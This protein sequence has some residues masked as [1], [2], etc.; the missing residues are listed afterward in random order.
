MYVFGSLYNIYI[1]GRSFNRNNPQA[2]VVGPRSILFNS[3]DKKVHVMARTLNSSYSY[4]LRS[5]G[6]K[7][8]Q[9]IKFKDIVEFIN[10][11]AKRAQHP[12]FGDL[13]DKTQA[14]RKSL[15]EALS[16]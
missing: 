3:K 13:R 1:A 8:K 10:R 15:H 5:S 6:K 9:R 14:T 11:P 4:S 16:G 7:D 2:S 12:V